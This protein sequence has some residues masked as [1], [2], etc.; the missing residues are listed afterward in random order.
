MYPLEFVSGKGN[1]LLSIFFD[2]N[3]ATPNS[4]NLSFTPFIFQLG[5][6]A[7]FQINPN[8]F[9][10]L[11]FDFISLDIFNLSLP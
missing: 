1:C 4:E 7:F 2:C 9:L 6:G 11:Y 3:F 5:T 10:C 8:V